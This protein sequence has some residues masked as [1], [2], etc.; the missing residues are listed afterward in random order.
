MTKP[1]KMIPKNKRLKQY[2][3]IMKQTNTNKQFMANVIDRKNIDSMQNKWIENQT[4][5]M[6]QV[7]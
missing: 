7:E 6:R 3:N 1:K 2:T 5:I 4:T